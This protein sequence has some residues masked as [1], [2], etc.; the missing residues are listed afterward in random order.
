MIGDYLVTQQ[1]GAKGLL[2]NYVMIAKRLKIIKE[3]YL[4]IIMERNF[5][6]PVILSSV[7]GGADIDH[8]SK[9]TPEAINYTPVDII[10][11]LERR[12]A[13]EIAEKID[14]GDKKKEAGEIVMKLYE[15]FIKRDALLIDIN[16]L[17]L[18]H[19]G[20]LWCIDAKLKFDDDAAYKQRTLHS[21]RDTS[22]E[23]PRVIQAAK[24]KFSYVPMDGNI[25]CLVSGAG[26][27]MATID[28]INLHGGS[29]ANFVNVSSLRGSKERLKAGLK[30]IMSEPSVMVVF[31]NIFDGRCEVIAEGIVLAIQEL[32][33]DVP[34]VCRLQ[35]RNAKDARIL[36]GMANL[37][38]LPVPDLEEASRLVVKVAQIMV[39]AK[40]KNVKVNFELPI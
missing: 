4:G 27:A 38:I 37:K 18:D 19:Q 7:H 9:T 2:C 28:I 3:F 31:I 22:Q 40:S 16:P 30:L 15:I 29:P 39:L 21:L 1:T 20:N 23:D 33:I 12:E 17:G 35:G 11:G 26:L 25:G 32:N 5:G 34:I 6:G 14:L 24:H 10:K 13:E 36:L 8:L